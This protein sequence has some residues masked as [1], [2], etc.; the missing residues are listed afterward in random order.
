MTSVV[1]LMGRRQ[2]RVAR[3]LLLVVLTCVAAC[4]AWTSLA[5]ALPA[6]FGSEGARAGQ[7][8]GN[9]QGIAVDEGSGDVYV[10]DTQNAR[11]DKFG[12]EGEFLLAWG[13]GVADGE[14]E[15]LQSC[16]STCFKGLE[17]SGAGEFFSEGGPEGIAVDNQP[18]GSSQG[19]VYVVDRRDHRVQK[20]GPDGEFLLMFGGDVNATTSGDLCRA[21][22]ACQ[23]G[24]EGSA[25][26]EFEDLSS[27][28]V[29]VDSEGTVYVGDRDRVQR[30]SEDGVV[31]GE[32]AFAGI[33]DVIDLAVDSAKDLYVRGDV[34]GVLGMHKYDQS[35]SELGSPRDLN[36]F[37]ET[38]AMAIGP[39]DELLLND[40]QADHHILAFDAEGQQTASFDRGGLAE[41]GGGGIAYSAVTNAIYVLNSGRVRIV[42]PPPPGPLVLEE[43]LSEV[44]TTAATLNALVNPEGP[45]ATRCRFEYG[46]TTAYG[47][48]TEETELSSGGPFEDQP[49]EK[50][51][52]GLQ[53][54]TAY[55]FRVSCENAAKESTSGP[56]QAFTTLPAVSID[57]TSSSQINATSARLE[58]DLNPHGLPSDYH[59]EYGTTTAYG[60]S[61]PVPDGSAGS[62]TTD[63][64]VSNLI[65]ELLPSTTYHY[66]V[67]AHNSLGTVIGP[68]RTFTTQ[69]PGSILA[70]GRIWEQVSPPNKH[71]A[72][73]EPMSGVGGVIQAAAGGGG[74][75][76]FARGPIDTEPQGNRSLFN[77]QVL[78][79]R[80]PEGWSSQNIATP[81]EETA[82]VNTGNHSE[83]TLF[84][85]DLSASVLEPEGATPLSPLTTERT[86][87]RREADG[88]F[89]PL[90]TAANV[91]PG[92]KFGGEEDT[93]GSGVWDF[94]VTLLT[95]TPDVGHVVLSS[96]QVLA[97]GFRAGFEPNGKDSL[98]EFA[99]GRLTLVSLLPN[100]EAAAEAGLEVNVGREDETGTNKRG[101]ISSDG[102]RVAFTTTGS[103]GHLYLRD[104]RLGQTLQLDVRQPGAAGG[105]SRPRFQAA[106]A[107]GG[108]VFFTDAAQLTAD[109]TAKPGEPDLYMC[110][111]GE[112][113]GQLSCA[114]SDL[115]VDPNPG[116]AASVVPNVSA[117][118]SAGGHVYFAASGAL[119]S[120]P[121]A[122]GEIAAPGHCV[123]ETG[124]GTCNLYAYDVAAHEVRLV[125]VLAGKDS[126]DWASP[127]ASLGDLTARSS[128]DGRFFAFMSR[129]SLTGYD[130]RDVN[131]GQPDEEVYLFDSVSGGLSCVSCDPTGA[132]PI[133][134]LDGEPRP[135]GLLIDN[136]H[137]W[138]NA[139]LAGTIPG[140]TRQNL[141]LALY[142]SRYLSNSG[143]M[144]FNSSD[145]LV[146]QDTN[147][148]M[149]V[150]EFEPPGVG[151]CTSSA[152][153]FSS[154]SG[155]CVSLVSSGSSEEES[156]FLDASES[157]DEVFFLTNARLLSSDVDTAFDVY[158]AHV[159]SSSSP[160]PPPPPPPVPPCEGDACQ[161]P[162]SPPGESTPS[163][164]TY[165]GPENPLPSS[166]AVKARRSLTRARL[167]AKALVSCRKRHSRRARVVCVRRA[168]RRYGVV[169][170]VK[171][172]RHKSNRRSG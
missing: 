66:R 27:R 51:I 30:F 171:R 159:C 128:P 19:D 37:A 132:R 119:T 43:S 74:L 169:V 96:P 71:G 46:T 38:M 110:Q 127:S 142:Q 107:D 100:E 6:S 90:V 130:N 57:G 81:H 109:A 68:D 3:T 18:L 9:P 112:S 44:S 126:P 31:E 56:D 105:K 22:E 161:H 87:Y 83:Y 95:A 49:I 88:Q 77:S 157:G 15:E 111:I 124:S 4:C 48:S 145:A 135:P 58:A 47:Q 136:S 21:G 92:T 172:S 118:D 155:G 144:F 113:E 139:W 12:P 168:R 40:L 78:S 29:A 138:Q 150:Y 54:D 42:T 23:A 64:T 89:V 53:P 153:T 152:S 33:G 156:A 131:S 101:A 34:R 39:G 104:T 140:W 141:A 149:D 154:T 63:T 117:I 125:A 115:S 8:S 16:T 79:R 41:N 94:G 60:K 20:F 106:S 28:S 52:E 80:G 151:D 86:P 165:R 91:P 147:R 170:S 25:P 160:C 45:E 82:E 50:A 26:G 62:T 133:G 93:P 61:V 116:E 114:L 35:G 13:W 1:L 11:I 73:I 2:Q 75:T 143:R 166:V 108:R 36:G 167:L 146:P 102:S 137:S 99:D 17:G 163:S 98:Y 158:D 120:A 24:V 76:Y 14:S 70:D 97:T 5:S 72:P 32:V 121:N 55:H 148:R 164:L 69:G 103:D 7:I 162:S 85:K 67:I 122:H 84:S 10:A 134:V 59:F 65:G 123:D 129:R